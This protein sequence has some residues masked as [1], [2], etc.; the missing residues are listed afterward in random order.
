MT[1]YPK[2]ASPA[3]D[4]DLFRSPTS[5]YRGTPFW[6]WNSELN[7]AQLKRQVGVMKAMGMGGYHIHVRTGLTIPYLGDEFMGIIRDLV[8][9]AREEKML[10][11]LYDEDRWPSGFGGGLVTR[12]PQYRAHHLLFTPFPYEQTMG[13]T[14]GDSSARANRTGNGELIARYCVALKDGCLD[15]YKLL[16]EDED[17]PANG[18][19]WYAYLE[20]ALPSPWFNNQT[21]VDT[22]NRKAI[23]RFVEITHERYAAV[24]GSDFGSVI[25]AIFTDE[26]QFTHKQF[27]RFPVEKRDLTLP[28]TPDILETYA[29]AY[30]QRLEQVLPEVIWELPGGKVS[31]VRYRYHDHVAERFSQAFADTI[32]AWCDK[33][34]IMLTGHMMEEPTLQSQTAALGDAMRSYR[35]FKLPGI[36]MLCDRAEY[37]TAKQAQSA[38]HQFGNPGVL[39]ELYGVTNWDF[40][41][42]GHKGQGDWQAALGVTVRVHHLAWVSMAGEAKRDYPASI[43]EQSPW[44]PEYRFVEDHFA[45]INTALTRGAPL[46]RVGVIH[47]I[48]SYWLCFGPLSQTAIERE[49]REKAFSDLTNWLLFGLIDFDYIAE[50]LLPAQSTV[51]QSNAFQVGKMAYD[52]VIVPPMHTIRAT[53]LQR[54]ESYRAAGGVILFAGEVPSLVDAVPSDQAQRLAATC[55]QTSFSH[56][57]VLD[58]LAPYREIEVFQADGLPA[59]SL[60]HQVRAD[61]KQRFVFLCNTDR[62]N[63]RPGTQISLAGSWQ[64]TL[65]DTL[66]GEIKALPAAYRAGK[67]NITWDF[68]AEGS[69][70]LQLE[71][72]QRKNAV[73][74]APAAWHAAGYLVDPAPVTLEEPNVLLLDQ[75]EFRLDDA[76]WQ[77]SEE[78]LRLDNALRQQL[79][80]PLR[81]R[82]IAQPWSVTLPDPTHT[83]SLRF[84]LHVACAVAEPSLA[85]EEAQKCAISL[86]GQ[87]VPV[88]VSGWWV[89]EAI[90]TVRL[91]AL[92]AGEH[93]LVVSLPYG[94]RTNPEWCYMLGD[95]GVEVRGRHARITAP[96]RELAFGD[97]TRQGLPFYAGNVTYH[98]K[99]N[100]QGVEQAVHAPKF[101]APLLTVALDGQRAGPIAFPPFQ[102]ELGKVSKGAHSLDITV[103]GSRVNAFGCVHNADE[104]MTWFGPNAWRT[105]GD[106]WAY[107]Y[108]LKPAG[109][110]TAPAI[111]VRNS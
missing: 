87:P 107:E 7:R 67:T 111:L 38:T 18:T 73:R 56:G 5:E 1:L 89:D 79:G 19:I 106:A 71:P 30:Q 55:R 85:I 41:F 86:D 90:Q 100:G 77:P 64:V 9:W 20:T 53:T 88:E 33:H 34:N 43:N 52:V 61:G 2:N 46:V 21:Y 39:S 78:V 17:A 40:P 69:L 15:A 31:L 109:L 57:A 81:S 45:R 68:P 44:W 58:A 59:N 16:A 94:P 47:P 50:S 60:L 11:W 28:W 80:W 110:L 101:V 98:L 95:F 83:L 62:L 4:P 93:E 82:N 75:A 92:S 103:Y 65:L 36:D 13:Q 70:L 35:G 54:L 76:T 74:A 26:P 25:P 10:A 108:Q 29:A 42:T 14:D 96:V 51:E 104:R 24:L 72:G 97:W 12:D 84:P 105:T 3:L 37:T 27:L 102:V 63:S 49:E 22:L 91:P 8:E 23:E 66:T 99:L 48:K 32:G 6:A